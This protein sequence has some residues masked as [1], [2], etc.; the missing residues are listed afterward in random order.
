VSKIRFLRVTSAIK[1]KP[2]M[3]LIMKCVKSKMAAKIED[4]SEILWPLVTK[5]PIPN[6]YDRFQ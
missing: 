3:C 2:V 5:M 4:N 6:E 1:I